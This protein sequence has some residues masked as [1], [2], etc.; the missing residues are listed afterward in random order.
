MLDHPRTCLLPIHSC[1]HSLSILKS[2]KLA[3][4]GEFEDDE[5]DVEYDEDDVEDDEDD[6]I[7]DNC[8]SST[9]SDKDNVEDVFV[10]VDFDMHLTALFKHENMPMA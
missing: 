7:E 9:V 8:K 1:R 10:V 3:E 2:S 5:Y 4:S 6:D